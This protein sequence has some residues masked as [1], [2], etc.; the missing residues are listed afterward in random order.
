MTYWV[1]EEMSVTKQKYVVE[2]YTKEGA[3][4]LYSTTESVDEEHISDSVF[5]IYAI[6]LFEYQKTYKNSPQMDWIGSSMV[7]NPR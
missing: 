5:S 3:I 7:L 1:V 2:S 6:N 4:E